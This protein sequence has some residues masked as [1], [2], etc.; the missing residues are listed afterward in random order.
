MQILKALEKQKILKK[1]KKY[2]MN[3]SGKLPYSKPSYFV[4]Y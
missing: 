4:Q 3:A 2:S 1:K